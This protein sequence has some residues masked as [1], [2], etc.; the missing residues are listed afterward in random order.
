MAHKAEEFVDMLFLR[1]VSPR[2]VTA[3]AGG[4]CSSLLRPEGRE[5]SDL[6]LQIEYGVP[7]TQGSCTFDS[8]GVG[9]VWWRL[10][11]QTCDSAGVY[12]PILAVAK[13]VLGGGTGD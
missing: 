12:A 11:L 6:W 3:K 9:D 10:L 8:P 5:L 7:W 1:K 2:Y 13:R 4:T